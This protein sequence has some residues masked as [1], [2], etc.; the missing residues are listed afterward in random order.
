MTRQSEPIRQHLEP[1][2]AALAS[3]S[4]TWDVAVPRDGRY[5]VYVFYRAGS[6]RAPDA[7]YTIHHTGGATE[8]TVDQTRHDLRWLHLG[9][10][11]FA[12]AVGARVTLDNR[13]AVAG[14]VA[15]SDAVRIG[16]GTG[17]IARGGAT[18]PSV[19]PLTAGPGRWGVPSHSP[20]CDSRRI[21]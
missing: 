14:R 2:H 19:P 15:I 17:S 7:R 16:D 1:R 3:A 11:W 5:P 9:D 13:S 10:F 6:N 8:V 12:Q 18:S 21:P 4:A 20:L